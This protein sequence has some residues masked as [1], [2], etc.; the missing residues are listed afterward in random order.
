VRLHLLHGPPGSLAPDE[1]LIVWR[2]CL[3]EIGFPDAGDDIAVPAGVDRLEDE[4][5]YALLL[6]VVCGL[7]SPL[8][9]ETQVMGQFKAFVNG[10]GHD[11]EPVRRVARQVLRDAREVRTDCLQGL[12]AR[13]YG[14]LVRQH[15]KSCEIAAVIGTGA[16]AAEITPALTEAVSEVHQWNRAALTGAGPQPQSRRPVMLI[17]AAPVEGDR[18]AHVAA[19]YS[20]LRGVIDLR[21]EPADALPSLG[22]PVISLR[23]LFYSAQQAADRA[24]VRVEAA[25]REIRRRSAALVRRD[26]LHPFGWDDLCA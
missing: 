14:S 16:L 3:R 2:T 26:E 10:L 18:V 21:G 8:A 13:A 7:R 15:V 11:A 22:V 17:V 25:R 12:G 23:D 19:R 9:G 4:A 6:E 5:A 1:T 24:A 20:D